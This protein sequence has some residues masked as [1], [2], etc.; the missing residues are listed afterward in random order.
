MGPPQPQGSRGPPN[1]GQKIKI[2]ILDCQLVH[3]TFLGQ[4]TRWK[5]RFLAILKISLGFGR[6]SAKND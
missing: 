3:N 5:H 1:T 2:I 6:F 4:G